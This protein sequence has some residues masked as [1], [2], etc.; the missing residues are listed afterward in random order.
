MSDAAF[1]RLAQRLCSLDAS[2]TK[3][4]AKTVQS[5]KTEGIC[6][7]DGF[8]SFDLYSLSDEQVRQLSA[9]V[10]FKP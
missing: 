9:L 7:S 1:E 4:V 10:H 5:F 2:L 8:F 3:E 6:S